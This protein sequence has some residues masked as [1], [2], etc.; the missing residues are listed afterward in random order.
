[1]KRRILALALALTLL[2]GCA[3]M[4]EREY[5]VTV[6]HVEDQPP[7]PSSRVTPRSSSRAMARA[8]SP[9]RSLMI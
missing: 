9:S 3:A 6:D 5:T 7:R 4:L 1:M 2:P 8:I